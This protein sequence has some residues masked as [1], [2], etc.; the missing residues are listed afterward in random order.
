MTAALLCFVF[1]CFAAGVAAMA[2]IFWLLTIEERDRPLE[3]VG[4]R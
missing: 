3:E 4:R 1:V 2:G